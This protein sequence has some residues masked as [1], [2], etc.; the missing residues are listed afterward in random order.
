M[1]IG[2][3][4][5][6]AVV[7]PAT[8][9]AVLHRLRVG[10]RQ[11]GVDNGFEAVLD[12]AVVGGEL[13]DAERL[14]LARP[15]HY[16]HP[17]RRG[18]LDRLD[19]LGVE[20][21]LQQEVRLHTPRELRVRHLVAERPQLRRALDA[22]QEVAVSAPA[23]VVEQHALVDHLSPGVHRRDRLLCACARALEARPVLDLDDL[24]AIGAQ[25]IQVAL[26]VLIALARNKLRRIRPGFCQI[27]PPE[28]YLDIDLREVWTLK[29]V[30][31]VR[32]REDQLS[33]NAFHR[34]R[35]SL[36]RIQPN[37]SP[38]ESWDRE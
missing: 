32:R 13:G 19:E 18:S 24:P 20:A 22:V 28:H 14:G 38:R 16:V 11:A 12:A 2:H 33:V 6:D 10:A 9:R 36:S 15:E 26:L 3:A 29:M 1:V 7:L 30:D 34:R 25:L 21:E 4:P 23:D 31:Q 37:R 17:L 35:P 27:Q 8:Q 5:G